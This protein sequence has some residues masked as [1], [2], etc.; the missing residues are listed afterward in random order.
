MNSRLESYRWQRVMSISTIPPITT[1]YSQT[2]AKAEV[3]FRWGPQGNALR[4]PSRHSKF[5][6]HGR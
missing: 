2:K 6:V 1:H 5:R 4:E 3:E